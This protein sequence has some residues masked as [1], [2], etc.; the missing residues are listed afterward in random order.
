VVAP[1]GSSLELRVS[2]SPLEVFEKN[3]PVWLQFDPNQMA[4][5]L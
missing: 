1:E 2:S 3:E 5:L 4:V